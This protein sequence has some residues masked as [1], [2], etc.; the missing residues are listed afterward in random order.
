MRD[1]KDGELKEKSGRDSGEQ[2]NE[3][4]E[5]DEAQQAR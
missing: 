3:A 1:G 4:E 5:E 2:E